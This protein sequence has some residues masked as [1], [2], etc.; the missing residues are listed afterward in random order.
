MTRRA[1]SRKIIIPEAS[2]SGPPVPIT[3]TLP[4]AALWEVG[5]YGAIPGRM[6]ASRSAGTPSSS[7]S[8]WARSGLVA[9][10]RRHQRRLS[11]KPRADGS[12]AGH[13]LDVRQM[14]PSPTRP[15]PHRPSRRGP[16][17]AGR[18][19]PTGRAT[20]AR[21]S[22]RFAASGFRVREA[23]RHEGQSSRSLPSG[24]AKNLD[25]TA[26]P[27]QPVEQGGQ[28]PAAIVPVEP[29]SQDQD[30]E[31]A[32]CHEF[33]AA[34]A[35]VQ[36]SVSVSRPRTAAARA[37]GSHIHP[38]VGI[39]ATMVYSDIYRVGPRLGQTHRTVR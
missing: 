18:G 14:A 6:T 20:R 5:G 25:V 13:C 22:R 30:L 11:L 27:F 10:S 38:A 36:P 31:Y 3:G 8:S 12:E 33:G 23:R 19:V 24:K 1:A 35:R 7:I 34:P 15:G 26:A 37:L 21:G 32:T 17:E 28:G 39:G 4:S 9:T 2:S 29:A 16:R